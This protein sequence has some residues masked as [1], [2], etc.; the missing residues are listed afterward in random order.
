MCLFSF[1]FPSCLQYLTQ[2]LGN[3][4][5]HPAPPFSSLPQVVFGIVGT[6]C[7]VLAEWGVGTPKA[8]APQGLSI[9]AE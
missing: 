6:A 2:M 8:A 5:C 1:S 4:I 3:V 9:K 7:F